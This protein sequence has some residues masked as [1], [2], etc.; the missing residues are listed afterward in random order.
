MSLRSRIIQLIREKY[1]DDRLTT[2]DIESKVDQELARNNYNFTFLD[3]KNENEIFNF[4]YLQLG[5][6]ELIFF[7]FSQSDN[8]KAQFFY[9]KNK[10]KT[11]FIKRNEFSNFLKNELNSFIKV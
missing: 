4:N 6:N 11:R 10:V 2:L 3:S 1:K 5:S 9:N 8:I 7:N